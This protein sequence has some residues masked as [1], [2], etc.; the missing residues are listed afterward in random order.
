MVNVV[1]K[2]DEKGEASMWKLQLVATPP[3][4]QAPN[5]PMTAPGSKSGWCICH[6]HKHRTR[7]TTSCF[8]TLIRIKSLHWGILWNLHLKRPQQTCQANSNAFTMVH[9]TKPDP[10]VVSLAISLASFKPTRLFHITP[11]SPTL[12]H[13]VCGFDVSRGQ[14]GVKHV[15]F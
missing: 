4:W 11:P 10:A 7:T 9:R 14:G 8:E 15:R 3:K 13:G 2:S 6:F 1:I 12:V 5:R